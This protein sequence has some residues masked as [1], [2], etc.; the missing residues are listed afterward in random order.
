[1][2]A[3]ASGVGDNG[4]LSVPAAD[5]THIYCFGTGLYSYEKESSSWYFEAESEQYIIHFSLNTEEWPE[6]QTMPLRFVNIADY[7]YNS[8]FNDFWGADITDKSTGENFWCGDHCSMTFFEDENDPTYTHLIGY[9]RSMLPDYSY[10]EFTINADLVNPV[11]LSDELLIP[12]ETTIHY[13]N[14]YWGYDEEEPGEVVV[15]DKDYYHVKLAIPSFEV[16]EFSSFPEDE[17]Y[18]PME[19]EFVD[20]DWPSEINFVKATVAISQDEDDPQLKHVDCTFYNEIGL[21]V[22]VAMSVKAETK[23]VDLTGD[24]GVMTFSDGLRYQIND[25]DQSYIVRLYIATDVKTGHFTKIKWGDVE[26]RKGDF[27][28][29]SVQEADVTITG[30]DEEGYELVGTVKTYD[31]WTYNINAKLAATPDLVELPAGVIPEAWAFNFYRVGYTP[32]YSE[33][34]NVAI[35]GND[36]YIQGLAHSCPDGW[37]RGTLEGNTVT[38]P[39]GQ[40]V[41]EYEEGY[42]LYVLGMNSSTRK[43]GSFAMNYDP[44]TRTFST[45]SNMLLIQSKNY[46]DVYEYYSYGYELRKIEIQPIE[47][48]ITSIGSM[49]FSSSANLKIVTT[50][51]KAYK[52]AI[53]GESVVLTSLEGYIPA[54]TG[55]VLHT[56]GEGCEVKFEVAT[57]EDAAADMT[58]NALLPTTLADG[59]LATKTG[60]NVYVMGADGGFHHYTGTAFAPNR[61]YLIYEGEGARLSVSFDDDTEG[62]TTITTEAETESLIFDLQGRQLNQGQ[63]GLQIRNGRVELVK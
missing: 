6:G 34:V 21:I 36:I 39:E 58:G 42:H 53:S 43:V 59:T 35:D 12:E 19:F 24:F 15:C 28:K 29:S 57:S 41:G 49:T 4:P 38:F 27:D 37:M 1:M 51:V 55:V 46:H 25:Y 26:Q 18:V 44:D 13:K 63:K 17:N 11:N 3:S 9:W 8:G 2:V 16:G 7:G 33:A 62:I 52:A 20:K 45:A 10:A 5:Q 50:G 60:D 32:K 30:S 48:E 56:P 31:H 61:A 54:G 22:N 40:Y 14:N 47:A 23:E